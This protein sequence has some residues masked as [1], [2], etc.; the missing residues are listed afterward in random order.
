MLRKCPE[1]QYIFE[2]DKDK[3]GNTKCPRCGKIYI[4]K[5]GCENCKGCSLWGTCKKS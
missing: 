1:C 2:Y 3:K 4:D 5:R